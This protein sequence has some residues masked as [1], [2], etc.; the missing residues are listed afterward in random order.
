MEFRSPGSIFFSLGPLTVRWYGVM[1]ALGFMSA[2]VLLVRRARQWNLDSEKIINCALTIFIGGIIG[3]RLYFVALSWTYFSQHLSEI[4]ATWN[5]GLS[6]HGGIVFGTIAGIIYC[7]VNQLPVLKIADLVGSV[8]PLAQAI[9]RWGNFFN[10][11]LFG[12]PVLSDFPVRL[13]IPPERRP[14]GFENAIYYHP[15]FLYE[16]L[17]DAGLFA[18]LY[19]ALANR[20]RKYPG[21]TFSLYIAG[22][23]L[24]RSLIEPLRLD[25]ITMSG[26]KVA[27]LVSLIWLSLSL[28]ASIVFLAKGKRENTSP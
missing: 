22:Y 12:A 28:V 20:L 9:G 5:G 18:L 15:A 4:A 6:I 1:I 24:G 27:L 25:S 14:L 21:L 11:E 3:A 13:F 26:Y 19:F 16:S 2:S 10:S 23:S 8:A 7:K 17:W